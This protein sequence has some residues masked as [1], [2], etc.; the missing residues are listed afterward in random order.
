MVYLAEEFVLPGPVVD[1]QGEVAVGGEAEQPRLP[2]TWIQK[3]NIQISARMHMHMHKF[4]T[5]QNL[6]TENNILW[7][8]SAIIVHSIYVKWISIWCR[9]SVVVNEP[10]T[11]LQLFVSKDKKTRKSADDV[12]SD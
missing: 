1:L 11:I 3:Y 10:K 6:H 7:K 9:G 5:P 12:R 4:K 8:H 2:G